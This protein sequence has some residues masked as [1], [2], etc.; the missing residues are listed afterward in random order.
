MSRILSYILFILVAFSIYFFMHFFVYK[1]LAKFLL[2]TAKSKTIVK[3]LFL[4]SALSFPIANVL[5]R[6]LKIFLLNHFA[7]LW[8]GIMAISFSFFLLAR[9]LILIFPRGAKTVMVVALSLIAVVSIYSLFNGLRPPRIRQVT[10]PLK[11][12]P[13]EISGF[14]IVQLSDL[15]FEEYKSLKAFERIIDRVN[16]LKPDLVVITGDLIDGN[17]N[18]DC[19]FCDIL[20]RIKSRHG[21][22]AVT[23][24][25]EFYSGIE[26]FLGLA[27]KANMRVLRNENMTIA[28]T[29][30]VA[31]TDDNAARNFSSKGADLDAALKGCDPEKPIILLNHRPDGFESAEKKGVDFQI[32]G[33]THAG[34]IP[35][36]DAL[37]YLA[38]K[39]PFGLY[40][41]NDSYIYTSSGTGYWGPPM[42]FLS[43]AEIVQFLLVPDVDV[44]VR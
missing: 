11:N 23:G 9:L 4:F 28:D 29:L 13:Q 39:Y 35:P 34:Q 27:R 30:Q 41:K 12:L 19:R 22:V 15:H 14:T 10:V 36:M 21:A 2:L 8:L 43:R 3:L 7:Y 38:V 26:S 16:S 18:D 44:E 17:L 31:G 20:K 1:T 40:R 37:V 32:S 24:N 42:R 25:H 5:S 33:H 6:F